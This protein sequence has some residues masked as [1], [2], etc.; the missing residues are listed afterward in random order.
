MDE[1]KKELKT[2]F[3]SVLSH[4]NE[5]IGQLRSARPSPT[6]VENIAVDCYDSKM[7]L[8][9]VAAISVLPPSTISI[10][11]WDKSIIPAIVRAISSSNLNLA[12]IADNSG[13]KL[14]LPPLSEERRMQLVKL[15]HQFAEQAKIAARSHREQANKKIESA[16]KDK[17]ISEDDKFR[18]KEEVQKL[19]D[20]CTGKIGDLVEKKEKELKE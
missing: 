6:M 11:P 3:E 9:E 5:E 4:F 2:E 15:L 19:T 20:E 14:N 10:E 12:P 1:I 17:K 16:F 7:A 18:V 13:I 8:R